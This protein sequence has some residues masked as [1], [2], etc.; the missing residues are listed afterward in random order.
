MPHKTGT[1]VSADTEKRFYVWL[2]L[3][4]LILAAGLWFYSARKPSAKPEAAGKT[5]GDLVLNVMPL[6]RQDVEVSGRYIGYVTPIKSVSVVPNVS[7]Y[8]DKIWVQGGQEV[9]AG[10]NL[11]LIEQSE[12][13]ARLDAAKASVAQAQAD[14]NNAEVYYKRMQKAG[15]KAVSKTEL[16]NAKAKYLSAQGAL[17]QAKAEQELARVN[18]NYTLL[19]APVD[20]VVGNVDLTKGNYVSPSSQPLLKI[21]QYNPIRVVF[22]ITDKEYL[23]ELARSPRELFAGEKIRLSL[24]GDLGYPYDG[25]FRF[26]DN[27]IDRSTNSIAVYADFP[28]PAKALVANAYVDVI[29]EKTFK[30]AYLIRQNYV[31]MTPEG[32]FAYIIK[33]GRLIKTSLNIAAEQNENYVVTNNFGSGEYLVVDKVGQIAPG[34]R[35]RI[36][37]LEPDT[38]AEGKD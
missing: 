8:L 17:A 24:G 5:A 23:A 6:Q 11:L 3:I 16:D 9:K 28:N 26:T 35:I 32:Y 36:K 10:D 7:G 20:G 12:Y 14:L 13:K 25:Q 27:E 22:S 37:V 1:S 21:I 2:L 4:I 34:R 19:T 31:S 30:N 33:D 29:L 18:L 38:P 15:A